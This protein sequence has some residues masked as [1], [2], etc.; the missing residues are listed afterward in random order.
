MKFAIGRFAIPDLFTSASLRLPFGASRRGKTL[1]QVL[2]MQEPEPSGQL[3]DDIFARTSGLIG[4]DAVGDTLEQNVIE[5]PDHG[6]KHELQS[7][8]SPGRND[9]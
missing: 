3:V 7:G 5:S 6:Y 8:N 9:R 4:L 2:K 1:L